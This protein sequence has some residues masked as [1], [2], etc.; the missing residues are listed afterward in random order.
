MSGAEIVERQPGAEL[1]HAGEHLRGIF[2]VL[3]HDRLGELELEASARQRRARQYRAQVLDQVAAQ[4]LARRYV[5]AGENRLAAPHGAL[6]GGELLGGALQRE[7]AEVDDEAGFFRNSDEFRRR[8][9][10]EL[11][12]VPTQQGLEPGAGAVLE[13]NDRLVQKT[14]LFAFEG[15][16]QIGFERE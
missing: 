9:S 5:D 1:A 10:A 13:A 15:T 4:E 11:G 12:M 14:D 16:T 7:Q 3:H 8:Q 6:P 2:R